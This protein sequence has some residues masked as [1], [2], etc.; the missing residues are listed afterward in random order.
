MT[1]LDRNFGI[2]LGV[3]IYYLKVTTFYFK[4]I[5]QTRKFHKKDYVTKVF[6]DIIITHLKTLAKFYEMKAP[7]K[8]P[9]Y[10]FNYLKDPNFL[11]SLLR[12]LSYLATADLKMIFNYIRDRFFTEI[13]CNYRF[14]LKLINPEKKY[15][16][17]SPQANN[18]REVSQA[19]QKI[20]H[21]KLILYINGL[22]FFLDNYSIV[23]S[24]PRKSHPLSKMKNYPDDLYFLFVTIFEL[25]SKLCKEVREQT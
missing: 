20:K 12:L 9:D 13:A 22:Q 10:F 4:V 11:Q 16:H 5:K 6:G 17:F 7:Y 3:D 25:W 18:E 1:E 14:F 2:F 21:L 24:P 15:I 19:I 8:E 23:G